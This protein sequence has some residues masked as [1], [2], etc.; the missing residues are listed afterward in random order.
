MASY[1]QEF[2]SRLIAD[3]LAFSFGYHECVGRYP[4]IS[5][6]K[7]HFKCDTS[8]AIKTNIRNKK[9]IY[10]AEIKNKNKVIFFTSKVLFCNSVIERSCN[11]P[12]E[13]SPI[14]T[15]NE[16]LNELADL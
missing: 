3:G 8:T 16:L 10:K 1:N 12:R 15:L 4:I 7:L 5:I 11:F 14:F 13:S 2:R 6:A 9:E